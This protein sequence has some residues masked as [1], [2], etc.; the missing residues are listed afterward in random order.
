MWAIFNVDIVNERYGNM[1]VSYGM[2]WL[3]G[4]YESKHKSGGVCQTCSIPPSQPNVS[5]SAR[6]PSILLAQKQSSLHTEDTNKPLYQTICMQKAIYD[7]RGLRFEVKKAGAQQTPVILQRLRAVL[8]SWLIRH[9]VQTNHPSFGQLGNWK[10]SVFKN[11]CCKIFH[12]QMPG[13][14]K[15]PQHNCLKASPDITN[16]ETHFNF[17]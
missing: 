3:S 16:T 17:H 6:L 8:T 14:S 5:Q 10:A 11:C 15:L 4:R 9:C 13:N 1:S 12:L 2:V 7:F